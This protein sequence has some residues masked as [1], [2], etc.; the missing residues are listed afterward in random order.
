[1]TS[2]NKNVIPDAAED[3][4]ASVDEVMKK[5]DRE[6]NTRVWEGTPR[7]IVYGIMAD[8]DLAAIR[9][10]MPPDAQYFLVAPRGERA[11]PVEELA[12]RMEGLRCTVCGSVEAGVR[13]ALDAASRT[14]GCILY[15]GGSTFVVAE[16]VGLFDP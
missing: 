12:A 14:P 4:Q 13:Q 16:A 3:V 5:F 8:K 7:L 10:L 1:M 15:I 11:L 6:S 9:P 2:E